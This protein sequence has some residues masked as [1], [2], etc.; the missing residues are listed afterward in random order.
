MLLYQRCNARYHESLP[1]IICCQANL[2][3]ITVFLRP[4]YDNYYLLCYGSSRA[5]AVGGGWCVSG[6][7]SVCDEPLIFYLITFATLVNR[8]I[9]ERNI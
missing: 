5:A 1:C 7:S 8:T 9:A 2:Q 3:E 6:R 4:P